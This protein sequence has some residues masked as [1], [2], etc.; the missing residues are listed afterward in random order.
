[1]FENIELWVLL[2]LCAAA[3]GAGLIDAMVGGGGLIQIPALFGLMPSHGHATLLGTNKI[4]SQL[5]KPGCFVN[6]GDGIELLFAE[7]QTIPGNI[8]VA[9]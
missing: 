5:F 3:F 2:A 4:S 7:L 9:R 1:M 6:R 8:V